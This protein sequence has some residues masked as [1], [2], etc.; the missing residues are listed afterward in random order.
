MKRGFFFSPN[1]RGLFLGPDT[2]TLWG[3]AMP[4]RFLP[5]HSAEH[6][7]RVLT[8][9]LPDAAQMSELW[10]T[11]CTACRMKPDQ[12]SNLHHLEDCPADDRALRFTPRN[13]KPGVRAV[14][15]AEP[16]SKPRE[17]PDKYSVRMTL[18]GMAPIDKEELLIFTADD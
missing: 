16:G 12:F 3:R 4:T 7:R 1:V 11:E 6:L 8:R 9:L 13:P 2:S 18:P 14:G 15:A 5:A 17:T 10:D